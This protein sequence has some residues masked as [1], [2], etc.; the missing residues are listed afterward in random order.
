MNKQLIIVCMSIHDIIDL[1]KKLLQANIKC[2]II[3]TPRQLSSSC[4]VSILIKSNNIDSIQTF[5]ND[6]CKPYFLI[7]DNVYEKE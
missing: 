4:G 3:P 1:E 5:L 6:R 7:N 2:D